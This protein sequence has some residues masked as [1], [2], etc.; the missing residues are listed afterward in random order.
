[1]MAVSGGNI[2][3]AEQ[4]QRQQQQQR[5]PLNGCA[6]PLTQ[7]RLSERRRLSQQQQQQQQQQKMMPSIKLKP[8]EA[9]PH[10]QGAHY[11]AYD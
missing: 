4:Q 7:T 6:E 3:T 2:S 5:S 11:R 9:P 10:S 1:M 8:L